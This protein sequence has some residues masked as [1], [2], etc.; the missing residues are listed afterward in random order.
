MRIQEGFG[1]NHRLARKRHGRIMSVLR[2][3]LFFGALAAI[4]T[5][6]T[7]II[8]TLFFSQVFAIQTITIHAQQGLNVEQLRSELYRQLDERVYGIFP[9]R[10][11]FLFQQ[12]QARKAASDALLVGSFSLKKKFP[13]SIEITVDGKEFQLLWYSKG[14]VHKVGGEGTIIGDA[15]QATIASL[16]LGLLRKQFGQDILAVAPNVQKTP[17][18]P[19]LIVDFRQQESSQ[20]VQVIAKKDLEPLLLITEKARKAGIDVAYVLYSR[21]EPS[22][23]LIVRDGWEVRMTLDATTERQLGM[24]S[25]LLANTIKKDRS[26]LNYIDVRFDNRAYYT[27]H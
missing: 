13:H 14:S 24:V 7:A 25:T 1:T 22:I 8:Y 16:P 12:D 26:K 9:Q 17:S 10:S 23:T 3:L 11:I 18:H 19:P 27:L 5:I 21:E 4:P 15:G 2:R 20:G 6:L